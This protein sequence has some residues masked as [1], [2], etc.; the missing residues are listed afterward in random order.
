MERWKY[1]LKNSKDDTL[2]FVV[3][4]DEIRTFLEKYV[5]KWCVSNGYMD[6]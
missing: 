5:D 3:A 4:I 1:F 2:A 6:Y